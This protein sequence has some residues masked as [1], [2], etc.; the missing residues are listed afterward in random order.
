MQMTGPT[1]MEIF[2]LPPLVWQVLSASQFYWLTITE[3]QV[4]QAVNYKTDALF[5]VH[6]L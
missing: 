1:V 5:L 4:L 2:S 6:L 3:I